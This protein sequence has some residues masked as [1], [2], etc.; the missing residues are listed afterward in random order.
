MAAFKRKDRPD[1]GYRIWPTLPKPWGRVGPWQTGF[2]RQRQ[3]DEVE[4]WVREMALVKPQ[5][6]DALVTGRLQLRAAW[7]AKLQ[8]TLDDLLLTL[9]DPPISE[10]AAA[11]SKITADERV[12][13]GV[14]ELSQLADAVETQRAIAAERQPP[15]AGRAR[16]SWLLDAKNV[17]E[18][19]AV[20][21]AQGW[22]TSTV[23]RSIHR[24]VADLIAHHFNKARRNQVMA[25]VTKPS[26]SDIREVRVTPD[27]LRAA[28]DA[29]NANFRDMV[30]LAM[31]LAVDREPLLRITPRLFDERLGTIGV[32]DRKTSSRPRTIELSTPALAILRTR[33]A[34]L[35]SD[36]RIF[37]WTVS[38]VRHHWETARDVAAGRPSRD[39][40]RRGVGDD[41]TGE[42]AAELFTTQRIVTL[43]LLRFKD[44]R[45]LL[46][47]AWN[48]LGL[49]AQD[50]K[51]IMGWARGSKMD[52]RYT[53]ARIQGDRESLDKVAAF[54][55]LDR[56]PLRAVGE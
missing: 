20:A 18:V 40:R 21:E 50:L 8:G 35:S 13:T 6:I 37:P 42:H 46:P 43:P 17:T 48:A 34:G 3:A 7:I 4:A 24:A 2:R 39:R 32:L 38:Q 25:D 16:L 19:Y 31:L 56:Y 5:L 49:P 11:F 51:G 41:A 23:K 45:H 26:G 53:T 22:S 27:E 14:L 52:E 28:L 29:C 30:V 55:G 12:R 15:R 9:S 1:E 36:E 54:L 10:A 47:T 44:L 33:C